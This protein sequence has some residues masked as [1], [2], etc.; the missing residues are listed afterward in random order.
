MI[1]KG[2]KDGYEQGGYSNE[3]TCS[4]PTTRFMIS[5]CSSGIRN[6]SLNAEMSFPRMSLP[7]R[8]VM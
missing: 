4:S 1:P 2:G 8:P 7:G 5:S 6:H 3:A